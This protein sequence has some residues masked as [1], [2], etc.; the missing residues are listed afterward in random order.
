MDPGY[1]P[2]W[3]GDATPAL[4]FLF[5]T[6]WKIFGFALHLTKKPQLQTRAGLVL[7]TVTNVK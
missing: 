7:L 5:G 2:Q 1:A 3:E 4:Y 6:P